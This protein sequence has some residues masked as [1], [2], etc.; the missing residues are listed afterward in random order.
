MYEKLAHVF[1]GDKDVVIG[2]VDATEEASLG[3]RYD[4]QGY[5]TIKFFPANADGPVPYEGGRDLES[6]VSFINE[7]TGTQRNPDGTLQATAGRVAVIDSLIEAAA[8]EGITPSLIVSMQQVI[9]TLTGKDLESGKQYLLI[10]GK[11][12]SKG[13]E[14]VAKEVQRLSK[15]LRSDSV[16]PEA[17]TAFQTKINILGSFFIQ[18]A[19]E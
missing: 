16:V 19:I 6:L 5:P 17:K 10:A 4:V 1:S 3:G 14:Y 8:T 2:K 12:L 13:S 7:Q 9:D 11:V 15:M 18:K